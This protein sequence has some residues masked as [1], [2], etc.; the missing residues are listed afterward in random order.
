M[1][2]KCFASRVGFCLGIG[3]IFLLLLACSEQPNQPFDNSK[4]GVIEGGKETLGG[5]AQSAAH[6][7]EV[8]ADLIMALK[9]TKMALKETEVL[10]S[11]AAGGK[12]S[13][14]TLHAWERELQAAKSRLNDVHQTIQ[15]RD[16]LKAK[17]QV[18]AITGKANHLNQQIKLATQ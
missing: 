9:E 11:G 10:L 2:S 14:G 16:Y 17:A 15:Q 3:N 13:D 7:N 1:T 18:R 6:N 4:P 5:R 8:T 12:I